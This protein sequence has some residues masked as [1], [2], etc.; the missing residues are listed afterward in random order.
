MDLQLHGVQQGP[1]TCRHTGQDILMGQFPLFYPSAALKPTWV[2]SLK[3]LAQCKEFYSQD[4]VCVLTPQL[5]HCET[6]SDFLNLSKSVFLMRVNG[7]FVVN[8]KNLTVPWHTRNDAYRDATRQRSP[9]LLAVGT[10]FMED[11]FSMD[12]VGGMVSGRVKCLRLTAHCFYHYHVSSAS[13]HQALDPGGWGTLLQ[14]VP[15]LFCVFGAAC[16]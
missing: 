12:Q 9:T 1:N 13:D 7:R 8:I 2:Q 14:G 3:L 15:G 4:C 16:I 11:D 6:V 5:F 10:V